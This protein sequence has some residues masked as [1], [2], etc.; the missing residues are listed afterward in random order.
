M[1]DLHTHPSPWR[2]SWQAFR[3]FAHQGW[4]RK[5]QVLGICEHAPRLNPKVPW[6][7]LY[8]HEM[9]RYF[10]T[11]EEIRMEFK[12]EMEVLRGLEVD[13]HAP[14]VGVIGPLLDR[15]GLDYVVGSVHFVDD[16]VIEDT[17]TLQV[18]PFKDCTGEELGEMYLRRLEQAAESGLFQ[19]MAHVDFIK[20]CWD[21]FGGKPDNWDDRFVT[22]A[23]VFKE[24]GVAVELNTRGWV[25]PEVGDAYP[26][27][28]ILETLFAA[29][30]P[31]TIGS[32]AH[33]LERVGEGVE[34]AMGVL[35]NIGYR[36]LTVFRNR[37]A[38]T[39]PLIAEQIAKDVDHD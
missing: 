20:K 25:L 27:H 12:G 31:V 28:E 1:I 36:E 8:F 13:Y 10:H 39:I 30:V 18:V 34:R 2:T 19:V 26:S 6:R 3:Q 37:V 33:S 9:D 23:K 32:D 4:K 11:L 38:R 16:W 15:Y 14:V 24:A 17:D 35:H 7:S 29:G 22:T 21:H 5:L